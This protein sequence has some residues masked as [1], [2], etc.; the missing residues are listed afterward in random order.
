MRRVF[1]TFERFLTP[2]ETRGSA[3]IGF[4]DLATVATAGND[5]LSGGLGLYGFA[6]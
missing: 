2:A 6:G 5:Y 4:L 1:R 3:L